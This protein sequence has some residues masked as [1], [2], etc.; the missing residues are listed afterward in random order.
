M[1]Q[2]TSPLAAV[3]SPW[4]VWLLEAAARLAHDGPPPPPDAV[5]EAMAQAHGLEAAQ[6]LAWMQSS[7]ILARLASA[8]FD[9]QHN[10][11]DEEKAAVHQA[12]RAALPVLQWRLQHRLD[13][14]DALALHPLCPHCKASLQSQGRRC[15]GWFSLSGALAL[16]RRYLTCPNH[17][18]GLAPAEQVVGLPGGEFT[19][20]LEDRCTRWATAMPYEPAVTELAE[21]MG[22]DLAEST[23]KIMVERR[24]DA[25]QKHLQQEADA[26]HPYDKNGLPRPAP[27]TPEPSAPE[28]SV[29]AVDVGYLEV[30]GA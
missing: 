20:F 26:L 18:G 23:L 12:L 5:A 30:D 21:M 13:L 15:R 22:L 29:P 9:P 16:D 11:Y 14:A 24:A 27:A 1:P 3:E 25:V 2:S 19:A 4:L 17:C 10:A 8:P 7:E 6:V 28:P